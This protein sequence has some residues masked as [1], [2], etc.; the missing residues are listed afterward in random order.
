MLHNG[1]VK[2]DIIKYGGEW[3]ELEK[4]KILSEVTKVQKDRH[5]IYS[6]ISGYVNGKGM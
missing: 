1:A 5:G 4:N 3:I 6:R 2:N